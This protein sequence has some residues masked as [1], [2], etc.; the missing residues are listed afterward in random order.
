MLHYTTVRCSQKATLVLRKQ[1]DVA[2]D[3]R[4]VVAPSQDHSQ[5]HPASAVS[6][7]ASSSFTSAGAARSIRR[8]R[9]PAEPHPPSQAWVDTPH[10]HTH[11]HTH[12]G[13]TRARASEARIAYAHRAVVRGG[14]SGVHAGAAPPLVAKRIPARSLKMEL[15]QG[16][17]RGVEFMNVF[18]RPV[19]TGRRPCRA[20]NARAGARS[21]VC[22][23]G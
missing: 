10:T 17:C 8:P 5:V 3:D 21:G 15:L 9:S 6:G 12:T 7:R 16:S 2:K 19:V 23:V 14:C 13:S 4:F 18:V 11:T 1:P 22:S 20:Y